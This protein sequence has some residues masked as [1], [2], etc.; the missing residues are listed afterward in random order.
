MAY[1]KQN[2]KD[3]E[4]LTA[5]QLNHIE[6]GVVALETKVS[7]V[8]VTKI[9]LPAGSFF[10]F[11]NGEVHKYLIHGVAPYSSVSLAITYLDP[12]DGLTTT[13]AGGSYVEVNWGGGGEVQFLNSSTDLWNYFPGSTGFS[14]NRDVVIHQII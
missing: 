13:T 6:D 1:T 5:E 8:G 9:V 14:A 3:G 7:E 4:V 11:P 10:S 2:F 12:V